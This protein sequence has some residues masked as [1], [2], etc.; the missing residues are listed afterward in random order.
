MTAGPHAPGSHDGPPRSCP[1]CAQTGR[2]RLG[3]E[4][5]YTWC[6]CTSCGTAYVSTPVTADDLAAYYSGYYDGDSPAVPALVQ[7]RLSELV[8][9][10]EPVRQSN[11]F[12]DV[13]F[14]AGTL[15]AAASARGW[16]CWGSEVSRSALGCAPDGCT[17]LHGDLPALALP[18]A[19]FD[20][21]C[22]VEL[23]EHV[24][25]PADQVRAAATA[26]RPGGLLYITTPSRSGLSA[27]LLKLDWSAWSA[28]EH[29][30]LM[31]PAAV[32]QLCLRHGFDAAS[33][34]TT[35]TNP[36]ELRGRLR[37]TTTTSTDRVTS[38]Y[39]LNE[40]LDASG[41]GR[42]LRHSVNAVLTATRLGDS[43][44]VRATTGLAGG[45]DASRH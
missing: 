18:A 43:I 40:R 24:L 15:L 28:P 29:L 31:T 7:D 13:G 34:R 41:G 3:E 33:V 32:R 38:G 11:R 42:W 22:M 35:G 39:E 6:A 16:E 14:G 12:L 10:F 1:A 27:R 45:S 36:H 9:T 17:V 21:V 44:K 23:L 2:R 30:Q 26:L 8:A 4:H 25:D 20:V 5:G 19:H 37:R